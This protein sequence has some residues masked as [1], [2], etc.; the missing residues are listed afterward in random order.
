[1]S[2]PSAS[3][4]RVPSRRFQFGLG[5]ALVVMTGTSIVLSL[6]SCS[7]VLGV[8][9]AMPAVGVWWTV[10]AI[11]AGCRRLAYYLASALFGGAT[12]FVIVFLCCSFIVILTIG[13][14]LPLG[15]LGDVLDEEMSLLLLSG[16][17]AVFFCAC[18]MR[19]RIRDPRVRSLLGTSVGCVFLT[20]LVWNVLATLFLAGYDVVVR[21]AAVPVDDALKN[22][23]L[24]V[25]RAVVCATLALPFMGPYAICACVTLRAIDPLGWNLA[26]KERVVFD[27]VVQLARE[28]RPPVVGEIVAQTGL[29]L[30]RAE[31]VLEQLVKKRLLRHSVAKRY[32]PR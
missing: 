15:D 6:M 1:M 5:A 17:L 22:M 2:D 3:P 32:R 8:A 4:A 30:D 10:L 13:E 24:L 25:G 20:A 9:V 12:L 31:D 14:R 7:V 23:V 21:G 28:E 18:V 19:R 16:T 11:R 29:A 27:A 26:G